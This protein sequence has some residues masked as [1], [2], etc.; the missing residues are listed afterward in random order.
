MKKWIGLFL[1]GLLLFSA[2]GCAPDRPSAGDQAEPRP[3]SSDRGAPDQVMSNFL[4]QYVIESDSNEYSYHAK[5]DTYAVEKDG[6]EYILDYVDFDIIEYKDSGDYSMQSNVIFLG[7]PDGTWGWNNVSFTRAEKI[8]KNAIS[9]SDPTDQQEEAPAQTEEETEAS[10]KPAPT[11]E[12]KQAALRKVKAGDIIVFGSYEQD[13]NASNGKEDIEWLVLEKKDDC[14]LVIS[15]YALD[16]QQYNT[17]YTSVTW[18]TCS[19]RKWLNETFINNAF[20]SDEQAIIRDT[21]VTADKNPVYDTHP[22]NDTTDKVFLL[23][24]T[25]VNKYFSNDEARKC[26]PTDYVIAQK[27]WTRND[28]S[29]GR[30]TCWWWLRSPGINLFGATSVDPA[31]AIYIH[32]SGVNGANGTVR[33]A[34]WIDLGT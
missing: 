11:S 18:E 28:N 19:L 3:V 34:M 29:S 6:E 26:V 23:S 8:E 27:P 14:M 32:G 33:P 1:A 4:C 10:E 2:I 31:G 20:S 17:F 12:S 13:N 9:A 30:V 16:C 15:R 7:R 22:G 21:K 25:E 5:H 24:I